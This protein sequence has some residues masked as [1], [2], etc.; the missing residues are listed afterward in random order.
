MMENNFIEQKIGE[1]KTLITRGTRNEFL[2]KENEYNDA[3]IYI[4][5][6]DLTMVMI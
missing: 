6:Y 3:S 4:T 5:I 1:E 2:L